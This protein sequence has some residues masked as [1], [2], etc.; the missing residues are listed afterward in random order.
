MS[1]CKRKK[2]V[3][4]RDIILK[5]L[6]PIEDITSRLDQIEDLLVNETRT[7][8]GNNYKSESKAR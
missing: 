6:E 5:G 4:Q 2:K 3:E 8:E 1:S 7:R